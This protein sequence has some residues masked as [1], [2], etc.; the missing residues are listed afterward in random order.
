M[1]TDNDMRLDKGNPKPV[2]TINIRLCWL[3]FT[4]PLSDVSPQTRSGHHQVKLNHRYTTY[5]NM[6]PPTCVLSRQLDIT[7]LYCVSLF[8]S[9]TYRWSAQNPF[10]KSTRRNMKN[11]NFSRTRSSLAESYWIRRGYT[12]IRLRV[13]DKLN[14]RTLACSKG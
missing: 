7:D 4:C 12:D 10:I 2:S 9:P 8:S 14:N 5:A 6:F 13:Y 3:I 1:F 11:E